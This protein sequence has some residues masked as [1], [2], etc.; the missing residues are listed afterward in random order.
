MTQ[1]SIVIPTYNEAGRITPTL[2]HYLEYYA[3]TDTEL[4]VVL[5]GCRDQTLA[6]V[7]A[8][9]ARYPAQLRYIHIPEPL[10]KGGAV[11]AGL[12]AATGRNRGFI[13]ADESTTPAEFQKLVTVLYE[14]HTDGVIASRWMS[15]S[16]IL[17]R[18]SLLRKLASKIFA[19]IVRH[20]F[21]MPFHDTQCG[22][23]VF[24]ADLV[25][26]IVPRLTIQNMTFDVELLYKAFHHGYGIIEVPTIWVDKTSS[27]M[28]SSPA[29]L[30]G[31]AFVMYYSL[32]SIKKYH[33]YD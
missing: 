15:Q 31:K 27:V 14:K 2:Q 1:L 7:Q 6:I 30:L 22:A 32:W 21:H 4:I 12:L 9:Q 26:D 19:F 23:K 25:T 29:Q 8:W 33:R 3:G 10:G 17:N 13:D 28:F 24:R 20:R 11:K 18:D 5:N 16:T